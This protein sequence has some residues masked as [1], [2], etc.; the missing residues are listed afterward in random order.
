MS[1]VACGF[2]CSEVLPHPLTWIGVS[3]M[4]QILYKAKEIQASGFLTVTSPFQGTEKDL[5]GLVFIILYSFL[6]KETHIV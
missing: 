4:G 3:F 2:Q 6:R 5:W 1:E